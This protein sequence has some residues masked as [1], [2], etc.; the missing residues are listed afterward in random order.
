MFS[1][2]KKAACETPHIP[3]YNLSKENRKE[4][5][6]TFLPELAFESSQKEAAPFCRRET[7]KTGPI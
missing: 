5:E 2:L 6:T 3:D 4:R 7:G 1:P